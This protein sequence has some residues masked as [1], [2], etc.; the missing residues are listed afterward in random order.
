MIKINQI[1]L[2]INRK[3][4][5]Y[6]A[7]IVIVKACFTDCDAKRN[8]FLTSKEEKKYK[9]YKSKVRRHE[10][11]LG[12]IAA[13]IA[14]STLIK[15]EVTKIQIDSGVFGQPILKN[16]AKEN[17]QVSISHKK[18]IAAAIVC[19]Q[20]HPMAIDIE[21]INDTLNYQTIKKQST[22]KE[23][24]LLNNVSEHIKYSLIWTIKEAMSKAIKTGLTTPFQLFE[25]TYFKKLNTSIFSFRS[26]MSNF[27]QYQIVS[28]LTEEYVMSIA[29]PKNSQISIDTEVERNSFINSYEYG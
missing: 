19:S 16:S 28:R 14:A 12:R 29:L 1:N 18:S 3:K 13:K 21:Y 24:E 9:G 4:G 2:G 20:E 8:L 15:E 7:N 25:V 6:K 23:L 5:T 11:L 27:S 10:F 26:L 17:L 22:L